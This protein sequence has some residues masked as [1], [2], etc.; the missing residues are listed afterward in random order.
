M[1]ILVFIKLLLP[2]YVHCLASSA[3]QS[4]LT[5]CSSMDCSLLGSPVHGILQARILEWAAMPSS[6]GSSWPRDEPALLQ[7]ILLTQGWN[8][9]SSILQGILPTQGWTCPLP[10]DPPD[11]GMNLPSSI[12][13]GIL[14]TQ[15]WNLPSSRGSSRPRDGPAGTLLHWLLYRC[16]TWGAPLTCAGIRELKTSL[17]KSPAAVT[18][19]QHF[20]TVLLAQIVL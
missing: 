12:L 10:G 14:L 7:G 13:Q 8:L 5:L 2:I 3:A 16:T 1:V 18:N 11:P 19:G 15:G 4:C 9:P 6:R 20:L 17:R